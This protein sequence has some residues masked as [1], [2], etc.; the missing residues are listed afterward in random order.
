METYQQARYVQ[1]TGATIALDLQGTV[2]SAGAVTG[3]LYHIANT[4]YT[5]YDFGHGYET[6]IIAV[7]PTTGVTYTLTVGA[8]VLTSTPLDATPTLAELVTALQAD[9]D[10][11]AAPFTVA[12][13]STTGIKVT[14]KALGNQSDAAV[15]TDD[16]LG[17]YT[18]VVTNGTTAASTCGIL[19][20][21]ER[22]L[23]IP[24]GVYVSFVKVS[25]VADGIIRL[26]LCE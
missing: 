26:T 15:L 9:G 16:A 25:G 17:V 6:A 24:S 2:T 13:N 23:V 3:G 19:A 14:W 5:H 8:V 1:P 20:A 22:Q 21:G 12:V 18:T 7:T 4:V 11:A 10:Y